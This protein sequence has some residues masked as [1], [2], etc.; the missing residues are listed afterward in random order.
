MDFAG[1]NYKLVKVKNLFPMSISAEG[2]IIIV[3]DNETFELVTDEKG[4][5]VSDKL[6]QGTYEIKEIQAPSGWIKSDEIIN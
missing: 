3:K 2:M 6:V 1:K 5:A 4:E